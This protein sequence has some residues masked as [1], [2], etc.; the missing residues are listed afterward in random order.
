[1]REAYNKLSRLNTSPSRSTFIGNIEGRDVFN[2]NV[3]VVVTDGFSGNIFLKTA[4][5]I[6]SFVLDQIE[7][8]SREK[9]TAHYISDLLTDLRKRLHYTEYPGAVVCGV[10]GIV[11]KCHGDGSTSAFRE[12]LKESCR[13]LQNNFLAQIKDSLTPK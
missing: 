4:E 3:S 13:L 8:A 5:G 11:I 10:D 6:A 9:K 12:S 2:G 1:M 7:E